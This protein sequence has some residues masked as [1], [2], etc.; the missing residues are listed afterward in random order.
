MSGMPGGGLGRRRHRAGGDFGAVYHR[1]RLQRAV[2]G[3]GVWAVLAAAAGGGGRAMCS[4][5]KIL[6][7]LQSMG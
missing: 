3:D 1:Q 7:F 5:R 4:A 6:Y 2:L